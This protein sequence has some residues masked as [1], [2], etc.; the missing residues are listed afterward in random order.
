MARREV[1]E[2]D[3]PMVQFIKFSEVFENVGDKLVGIYQS[4]APSTGQYGGTDYVFKLLKPVRC[5]KAEAGTV[6]AGEDVQMTIKGV[7]EKQLASSKLALQPGDAVSATFTSSKPT[8]KGNEQRL[9]KVIADA[10]AAAK[11]K[12]APK[13]PVEDD[14]AP[15]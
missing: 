4:S 8:S 12:A 15:F 7:L 11:G 3:V 2:D 10:P 14:D 1:T 9:F 5:S 6:R 13:P